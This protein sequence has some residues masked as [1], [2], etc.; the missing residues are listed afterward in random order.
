SNLF[1]LPELNHHL[2]EGLKL[3]PKAKEVLHFLFFE[4]KLYTD[5][6]FKR[7]SITQEVVEKNSVEHSVYSVRS[8]TKPEQVFELLA[9]SSFVTF[10]LA[11]LSGTDP[12]PIP[13]VDYFKAKL[14]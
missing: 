6:V 2:M 4:S 8:E 3:P 14:K 5:R 11:V 10:Y 13:W 9:L 7:Y 12:S 1:D